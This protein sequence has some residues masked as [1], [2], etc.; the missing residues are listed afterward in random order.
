MNNK[1]VSF[2]FIVCLL[3]ISQNSFAETGLAKNL[4]PY[5]DFRLRQESDFDSTQTDRIQRKDRNRTRIRLR[6]GLKYEPASYLLFN[7]RA[8]T[9]DIK[10]QQSPHMTIFQRG[11]SD[12]EGDFFLDKLVA[13]LSKNNIWLGLG[14]DDLPFWKQNELLW[15]DDVYLDG[16]GLG[17]THKIDGL[18]SVGLS[19]GYFLLPDGEDNYSPSERS[20]IVP[21]QLLYKRKIAKD[22]FIAAAGFLLIADEEGIVNSTNQNQ[23][24]RIWSASLQYKLNLAK[25]PLTLGTDYMHNTQDYPETLFNR[26]ERNGYVFQAYLGQLKKSRD[27][28]F[29]YSY[30]HI[31][32]YAVA[33][34]FAQDDWLRWGTTTQTRSSN[35]KGHEFR[36]GYAFSAN[37][38]LLLRTYLVDGIRLETAAATSREDGKR[39]RLDLNYKF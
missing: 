2:I 33:F 15:D 5:G 24:Y 12:I 3:S 8:R 17:Y 34:S 11:A 1:F 27:W 39:V 7:L 16:V 30:A 22:D 21:A 32:K 19:A 36:L 4:K 29:G 23:D 35:F 25:L 28:L 13:K 6:L 9:G 26:N 18:S 31:E 20:Q 10:S 14:R 37:L 38:N